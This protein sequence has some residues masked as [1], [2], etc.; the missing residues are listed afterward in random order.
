M[1]EGHN[2]QTLM[3]DRT[4]I[5]RSEDYVDLCF[6]FFDKDLEIKCVVTKIHVTAATARTK[7][8][9]C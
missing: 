4:I 9:I 5:R 8:I 1:C 7:R 3:T 6:R 2:P